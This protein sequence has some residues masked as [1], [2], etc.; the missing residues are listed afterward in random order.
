MALAG[1]TGDPAKMHLAAG[2]V[3]TAAQVINGLRQ[4]IRSHHAALAGGWKS[5]ASSVYQG[6][7]ADWDRR[8]GII[9]Q[10]LDL[11]HQKLD[12]NQVQYQTNEQDV[13]LAGNK[14]SQL[15]NQ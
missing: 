13:A 12:S 15:L 8:L 6:V 5:T 2:Q 9:L 14:I 7:A 4:Q 11:I 1:M 10:N 3:D